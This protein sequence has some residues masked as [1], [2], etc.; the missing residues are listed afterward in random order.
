M[1][2]DAIYAPDLSTRY[3]LPIFLGRLPAGFPSPADDYIEGKLD[4]NRKLIKHPAATFFVKVTGNS[5]LGAGIHNGDLLVVDKSLEAVDGNVIVASLD[6]E[7]TVKRLYKRDNVLRLLPDNKDYQPIEIQAQQS[8]EIWGVVTN[9][10]H[11][12]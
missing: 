3:K 4:L 9:V 10:I 7:L 11:A 6:G 8:F 12:L 5:M 2:V 1:H